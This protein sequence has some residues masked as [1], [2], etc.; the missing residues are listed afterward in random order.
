MKIL[1]LFFMVSFS[2]CQTLPQL[3]QSAED[4]LDDKA[5][6]VVISR[7]AIQKQTNLNITIDVKNDPQTK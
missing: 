1:F 3:Y 4:I 6:E 5:I 2:S 7:E